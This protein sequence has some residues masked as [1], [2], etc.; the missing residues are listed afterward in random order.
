MKFFRPTQSPRRQPDAEKARKRFYLLPGMGG[1]AYR[2]KRQFMLKS[3][4][5]VGIVVSL[6]LAVL[7]YWLNRSPR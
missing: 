4:L 2:R 5:A 6:V 3:A 1:R 7:L